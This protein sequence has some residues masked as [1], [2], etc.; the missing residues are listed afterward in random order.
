MAPLHCRRTTNTGFFRDTQ[1]ATALFKE[2]EH[3]LMLR[4]RPRRLL[5]T[6]CIIAHEEVFFLLCVFW[7]EESILFFFSF[8]NLLPLFVGVGG[9]T[10][11]F[12]VAAFLCGPALIFLSCR[13]AEP[14]V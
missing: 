5:P 13:R 3:V 8:G 4:Q 12:L 6:Y 2:L 10:A 11:P 14:H 9:A 7:F 1:I